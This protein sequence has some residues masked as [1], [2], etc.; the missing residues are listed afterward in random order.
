MALA[1]VG[2]LAPPLQYAADHP[3]T[4]AATTLRLRQRLAADRYSR[5]SLPARCTGMGWRWPDAEY[6]TRI[7]EE[8]KRL[9]DDWSGLP[10]VTFKNTDVGGTRTVRLRETAS[11][12]QWL[13]EDVRRRF[14]ACISVERSTRR[15]YFFETARDSGG[16]WTLEP[17]ADNCYSCHPG[18]PRVI[19]TFP[20][21]AD[22]PARRLTE[23]NRRILSYGP[24]DFWGSEEIPGRGEPLTNASCIG[25]HNGAVRPR[26][27]AI[28]RRAIEFKT[29]AERSMP[30][31]YPPPGG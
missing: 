25:C 17:A 6:F 16:H 2:R 18:G 12:D 28:H 19:R 10:G 13:L 8:A 14:H 4:D 20:E 22:S 26:L 11:Y 9:P 5:D 29:L 31:A 23:F 7:P 21:Q 15:V 30:P 1:A 3:F 27:Y 24:C